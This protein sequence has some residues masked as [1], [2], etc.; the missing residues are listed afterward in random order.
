[1]EKPVITVLLTTY[2]RPQHLA[3]AVKSVLKQKKVNFELVIID[4]HSGDQ[5]KKTVKNFRDKRI[6]Y[7]ENKKNLG[8]PGTFR[9]GVKNARG[10]YIFL[11]SDD[12]LIVYPHTLFHVYRRMEKSG[13]GF[14]QTGLLFYDSTVT[15]PYRWAA[16]RVLKTVYHPPSPN[17]IFAL[18]RWH[19]GFAS[20]NIYKKSLLKD[21]DIIEDI[22]F[23]HVKPIYRILQS[24]GALYFGDLFIL[25]K[26]SK[27]GNVSHLDITVNKGFHMEKMF[28]L[29]REFDPSKRR[30]QIFI[31]MHL[32]EGAIANL[33]G[34]KLYTSNRNLWETVQSVLRIAPKYRFSIQLW[35]NFLLALLTPKFLISWFRNWRIHQDQKRLVP[36]LRKMKFFESM[37]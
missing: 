4:D 7:F 29:Y 3:N 28:A 35:L 32:E 17:L 22:W 25:G 34:I 31:S 21:T 24:K 6:R 16:P 26:I 30:L 27:T 13:A 19:F 9:R 1:M 33:I 23:S 15:K 18:R 8:F 20:G 37:A 14:G 5:T 36:M 2:R 12:D 11:L 10:N